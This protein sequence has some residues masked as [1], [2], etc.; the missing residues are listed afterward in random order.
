M[1]GLWVQDSRDPPSPGPQ[2]LWLQFPAK[3][4]AEAELGRKLAIKR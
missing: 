2:L 4:D 3:A 1:P